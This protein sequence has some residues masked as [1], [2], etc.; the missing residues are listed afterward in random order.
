ML[1]KNLGRMDDGWMHSI[2]S[3]L[4]ETDRERDTNTN[5]SINCHKILQFRSLLINFDW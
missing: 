2:I 1:L 4:L 3:P 5:N